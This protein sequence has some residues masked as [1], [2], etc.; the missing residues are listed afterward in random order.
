MK[1]Y[2]EYKKWWIETHANSMEPSLY[3]AD[4]SY[5]AFERHINDLG[6]FRLM[7]LLADW[8]E[9][10]GMK[11]VEYKIVEID[12]WE[13]DAVLVVGESRYY[14]Q[15]SDTSREPTI[16]DALNF[17]KKECIVKATV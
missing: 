12:Y 8:N 7:E 14:F 2:I 10:S 6:L 1:E 17:F 13:N 9:D 5:D 11:T 16:I 3:W 15:W 4:P